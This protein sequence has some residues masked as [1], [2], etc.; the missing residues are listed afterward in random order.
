MK[1]PDVFITGKILENA[2]NRLLCADA[3]EGWAICMSGYE[4]P[5]MFGDGMA[6]ISMRLGFAAIPENIE[7]YAKEKGWIK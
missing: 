1:F 7:N 5:K 3:L 6:Q 4:P 2:D